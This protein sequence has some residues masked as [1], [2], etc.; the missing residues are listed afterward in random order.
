MLL[1]FKVYTKLKHSKGFDF[2]LTFRR[3]DMNSIKTGIKQC[4]AGYPYVITEK[5][6]DQEGFSYRRRAKNPRF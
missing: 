2:A 1:G 5:K 3:C 4:L 6:L